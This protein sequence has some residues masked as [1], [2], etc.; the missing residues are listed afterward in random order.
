MILAIPATIFAAVVYVLHRELGALHVGDVLRHFRA[1][2]AHDLTLATALTITS[3]WLLSFYDFLALRYLGRK[4]GYARVVMTSFVSYALGH[5]LGLSAFT[6]AAVRY[7]LYAPFKLSLTDVATIATFCSVTSGVGFSVLTGASLALEPE[8]ASQALHLNP[9]LIFWIGIFLLLA[10]VAYLGWA[11]NREHSLKIRSFEL[12]APGGGLAI[13]QLLL[14]VLDLTT[15]A[16]V[17]WTLLPDSA[18][19][20]F[21][22]FAGTYAVA[23]VVGILSHVP[24]G[25]GVLESVILLALPQVPI[26]ALLGSL[27]AYR[28][29]YYLLPL[30]IA[31]IVFATREITAYRAQI[32]FAESAFSAYVTPIVPQIV[33]SLVFIA[34]AILLVSGATP[35]VD[36]RLQSLKDFMPLSVL[37]LSHLANSVVGVALLVLARALFRRVRAAYQLTTWLLAA[38]IMASLLKGLDFEEAVFLAISLAVLWVGRRAFYRPSSLLRERFTLGWSFSLIAIIAV[39]T[40]VGFIAH[41]DVA[42]SNDLWWTFAVDGD[43]PRMLRASLIAAIVVAGFLARNLLQARQ[44]AHQPSSS[45]DLARAR[46]AIA[47]AE[48]AFSQ[49][50]LAGDKRL[51]F[52]GSG[53][54]FLMY[55]V[56]RR[57][58]VALGDPVGDRS[59]EQELVWR[60]RDLSDREGGWTVF[61]QVCGERLP[62]YVDL[63]LTALKVGEEAR[64]PLADFSLQ[65]SKS[66]LR[67]ALDLVASVQNNGLAGRPN[68]LASTPG[69]ALFG[70]AGGDGFLLGGYGDAV[71]QLFSRN[72]P[73]YSIGLR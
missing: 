16:A 71:S 60:F 46:K 38:G 18:H 52:S 41:R 43:A 54:S 14:A 1:I 34:G 70:G 72:F 48:S 2:P 35:A 21:V 56:M 68:G 7:R 22:T 26:D 65:G 12:K 62:I 37:E 9:E 36:T 59:E 29:V 67:P 6:G 5:N 61:Y 69:N 42:Y 28:I 51:L 32:A 33:G 53:N 49:V 47:N 50:A 11:A 3:Y 44:L 24:G 31:T 4:V 64:V 17:L 45:E 13:G 58:W 30:A 20:N 40:W 27:L 73:D 57:S 39:A 8:N 63:G 66:A 15:A 10:I 25:L 23:C 19:V 55:Q